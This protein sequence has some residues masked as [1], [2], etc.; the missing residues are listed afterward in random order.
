MIADSHDTLHVQSSHSAPPLQEVEGVLDAE[1]AGLFSNERI[2]FVGFEFHQD[3]D[4]L[5]RSFPGVHTLLPGDA[6]T[7]V[8]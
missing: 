4:M 6:N 3:A 2:R 5:K 8:Q 1:L 7:N